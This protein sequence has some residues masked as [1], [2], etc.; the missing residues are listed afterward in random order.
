[1]RLE[2]LLYVTV[3]MF[4]KNITQPLSLLFMI[5]I[6]YVCVCVRILWYALLLYTIC[7]CVY[8]YIYVVQSYIQCMIAFWLA[9]CDMTV[10]FEMCLGI[11]FLKKSENNFIVKLIFKPGYYEYSWNTNLSLPYCLSSV[12]TPF[13]SQRVT[14]YYMVETAKYIILG[15]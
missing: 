11:Y 9:F 1:M 4:L 7:V 15:I 5:D 6:W 13:R 10:V 12:V 8:I 2:P 3:L 14:Y